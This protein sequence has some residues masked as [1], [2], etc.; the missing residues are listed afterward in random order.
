M[1]DLA[2]ALLVLPSTWI[3]LAAW[4]AAAAVSSA[5]CGTGNRLLCALGMI[6]AGALEIG[7]IVAGSLADSAGTTLLANPLALVP[8]IAASVV[9][10]A[11][12]CT[13]APSRAF[14]DEGE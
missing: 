6:L 7:A 5:L 9:A 2:A 11:L 13:A 10:I 14:V 8:V 4:I 3:T 12:T 1:Q